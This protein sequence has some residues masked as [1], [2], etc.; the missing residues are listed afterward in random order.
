MVG[1]EDIKPAADLDT[2]AAINDLIT[3]WLR[4]TVLGDRA[5]GSGFYR[6]PAMEGL[7]AM[8]LNVAVVGWLS[9]LHAAGRGLDCVD[10]EAARAAIGRVDR[11]SG[12]ALWLGSAAERMR[13]KYLQIDDGLRRL[14]KSS[15]VICD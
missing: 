2:V 15:Q 3:R 12:R 10:L 11:T 13:L 14:V 7:H 6:W 1:I 5:W 4:A 9:R 8:L